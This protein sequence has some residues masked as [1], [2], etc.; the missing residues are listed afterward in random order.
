[1]ENGVHVNSQIGAA[2]YG[3]SDNGVLVYLQGRDAAQV[4]TN[5]R[6]LVW[7]DRDG[8]EESLAAEAR[9]YF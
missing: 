8:R 9:Q 5:T 3:F 6:S 2:A 4:V 7:V 1:M